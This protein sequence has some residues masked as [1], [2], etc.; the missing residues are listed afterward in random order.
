MATPGTI[1]YSAVPGWPSPASGL[2]S[3]CEDALA[4]A[5]F[6]TRV[7][8]SP[9]GVRVSDIPTVTAVLQSYVGGAEQL[10]FSKAQKQ[11]ALDALFDANFDLAKFI[12]GGTSTSITATNVGTFLATITNNYRS[13]RAQISTAST[14][15][16]LNGINISSGW[17][18][19]P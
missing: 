11:A 13:L 1:L 18:S 10:N 16:I 17:P 8:L 2:F 5:G 6:N 3:A 15:A 14:L 12:R 9:D 19:N 7:E 4:A